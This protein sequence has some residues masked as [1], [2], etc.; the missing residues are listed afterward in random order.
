MEDFPLNPTRGNVPEVKIVLA[1]LA[2]RQGR[3]R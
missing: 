3:D 2:A 1:A